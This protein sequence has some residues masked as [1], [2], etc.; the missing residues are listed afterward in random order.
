MPKVNVVLASDDA[1][2]SEGI[3]AA[4]AGIKDC[5]LR[6]VS[7]AELAAGQLAGLNSLLIYHLTDSAGEQFVLRRLQCLS[8]QGRP[9][10]T[11]VIHDRPDP[12][13]GVRLM[14][15]GAVDFLVRPLDLNRLAFLVDA[16]TLRWRYFKPPVPAARAAEVATAKPSRDWGA[17]HEVMQQLRTLAPL[18]TTILLTG[19]TGTGKTRMA[20]MIH[21]ISPRRERP[22]LVVNCAAIA[23]GLIESELFGHVRGAF[24]GAETDRTGKLAEAGDGTLLLDEIDALSLQSQSRL[25]R[26]VDERLFEPVGANRSMQLRAR[27]VVASNGDLPSLVADGKFRED[28]YYRLNVAAFELPA[29]RDS[30]E[31]IEGLANQFAVEFAVR[32]GRLPPVISAEVIEVLRS[33]DW[34]GNI[35]ELRNVMERAVALC[36]GPEITVA[37]LPPGMLSSD[38]RPAREAAPSS[39]LRRSKREA[40]RHAIHQALAKHANNRVRTARELGISRVTLYKKLRQYGL[41]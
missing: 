26:A 11:L 19:E 24:T 13:L 17:S 33:F 30:R 5:I 9:A 27:L 21:E 12:A 23:A 16:L 1:A 2:L 39:A 15:A 8:E 10:P 7:P 35:R 28:L 6:T 25:L 22:F 20:R 38:K 31:R 36:A 4:L 29:L 3:A 14:H 32:D 40:E 37:D 18:S 41:T 34:P